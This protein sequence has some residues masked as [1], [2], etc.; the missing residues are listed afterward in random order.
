MPSACRQL[1]SLA[2]RPLQAPRLPCAPPSSLSSSSQRAGRIW[3]KPGWKERCQGDWDRPVPAV[4]C[5]LPRVCAKRQRARG[6]ARGTERRF[7]GPTNSCPAAPAP[8]PC[9]HVPKAPSPAPSSREDPFHLGAAPQAQ[10]QCPQH[11]SPEP[12]QPPR[13]WRALPLV[14]L[15]RRVGWEPGA[16][17]RALLLETQPEGFPNGRCLLPGGAAS[18]SPLPT[19]NFGAAG[20]RAHPQLLT[21]R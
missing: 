10:G 16:A 20:G 8:S 12:V 9:R 11:P 17:A 3:G 2:A 18:P 1:P 4:L 5:A 14:P 13:P 19:L 7:W 15:S 6:A 21:R